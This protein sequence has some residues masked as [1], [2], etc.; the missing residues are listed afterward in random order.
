MEASLQEPRIRREGLEGGG[1]ADAL[2]SKNPAE[3]AAS[4]EKIIAEK[5]TAH[6]Q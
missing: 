1:A 4:L 2:A 5:E 6:A 3:L